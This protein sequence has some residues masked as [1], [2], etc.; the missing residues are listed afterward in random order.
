MEPLFEVQGV[1]T[2]EVLRKAY[3]VSAKR[4]R[5]RVTLEYAFFGGMFFIT[6]ALGFF[7]LYMGDWS[8]LLYSLCVAFLAV[9]PPLIQKLAEKTMVT[10]SQDILGLPYTLRFYPEE[11]IDYSP[12]GEWHTAYAALYAVRETDDLLLLYQTKF[13]FTIIDKR[14]FTRGTPEDLVRF[15]HADGRFPCQR[16]SM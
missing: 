10:S 12:R 4:T 3:R 14:G 5:T 15:L 8:V 16:L 7:L 9:I 13:K 11:Y 1:M 2:E 6:L